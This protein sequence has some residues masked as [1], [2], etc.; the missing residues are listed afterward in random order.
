MQRRYNVPVAAGADD[1]VGA[2]G[3]VLRVALVEPAEEGAQADNRHGGADPFEGD[4]C[5]LGHGSTMTASATMRAARNNPRAMPAAV[6]MSCLH[7]GCG[8]C[9]FFGGRGDEPHES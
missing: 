1:G 3:V 8:L 2:A 4:L 9:N 6:R 5:A 7:G